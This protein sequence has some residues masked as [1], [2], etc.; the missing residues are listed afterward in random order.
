VELGSRGTLDTT[1][2]SAMQLDDFIT[3]LNPP[4]KK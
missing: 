3:S 4:K 2:R 1:T